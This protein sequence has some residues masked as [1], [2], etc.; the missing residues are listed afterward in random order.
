MSYESTPLKIALDAWRIRHGVGVKFVWSDEIRGLAQQFAN[1]GLLTDT[2]F[3]RSFGRIKKSKFESL[4]TLT[5]YIDAQVW[6]LLVGRGNLPLADPHDVISHLPSLLDD[7]FT[8]LL[9]QNAKLRYLVISYAR[10]QTRETKWA[11]VEPL[12]NELAQLRNHTYENLSFFAEGTTDL[13]LQGN[14]GFNFIHDLRM[15]LKGRR[16]SRDAVETLMSEKAF[17][18]NSLFRYEKF[19]SSHSSVV[20]RFMSVL[21]QMG[22]DSQDAL[23]QR[24][25]LV[26]KLLTESIE[27]SSSDDSEEGIADQAMQIFGVKMHG[28]P[29]LV[30]VFSRENRLAL[31]EAG[32]KFFEAYY[33]WLLK[34]SWD[35]NNMFVREAKAFR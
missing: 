29:E 24:T 30:E 19:A 34:V 35:E 12:E 5:H 3:R 32:N 13:I 21:R 31:L 18:P 25:L 8:D 7:R 27:E 15:I 9:K 10:S 6:T 16:S 2:G 1:E 22:L 14:G 26:D 11:H 23:D 17:N 28:H 33:R 4:E 20:D